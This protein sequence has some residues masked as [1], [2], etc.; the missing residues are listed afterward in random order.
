MRKIIVLS[1]IG[2]LLI[3]LVSFCSCNDYSDIKNGIR[4]ANAMCPMNSV[5][6]SVT[7]L[8]F[9][10]ARKAVIIHCLV[11]ENYISVDRMV[12]HTDI[13]KKL[14]ILQAIKSS[15][16]L[17]FYVNRGLSIDYVYSSNK[18]K[19]KLTYSLTNDELK[20]IYD[21]N[22]T[23][24]GVKYTDLNINELMLD[25]QIEITRAQLPVTIAKGMVFKSITKTGNI[26]NLN[27]IC[28][29]DGYRVKNFE[30][31]K[32]M[33]KRETLS[34]IDANDLSTRTF[35]QCCKWCHKEMS[36]NYIGKLSNDTVK[37]LIS[38]EDITSLLHNV[39][40]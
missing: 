25:N 33:I 21:G 24:D 12:G 23:I 40:Y 32:D 3:L 20:E 16:S 9:D 29:E 28:D 22:Y 4:E 27:Y 36:Y 5:G 1:N 14:T 18:Y 34:S 37:M 26:I 38:S 6:L 10:E 11:D 15:Q 8:E 19:R 13:L 2:I 31:V 17:Q 39:N 7:S 30:K 35:L